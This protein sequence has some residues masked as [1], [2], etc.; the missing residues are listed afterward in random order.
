MRSKN[1]G[2]QCDRTVESVL[3]TSLHQHDCCGVFPH[4]DWRERE[5]A[6]EEGFMDKV[7]K[8]SMHFMYCSKAEGMLLA[9]WLSVPICVFREVQMP[10]W[11]AH[12]ELC[13][14]TVS[15]RCW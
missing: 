5:S 14:R 4:R 11:G 8:T 2:L 10:A 9:A 6:N 7:H 13:S 1:P 3:A 12:E 15:L